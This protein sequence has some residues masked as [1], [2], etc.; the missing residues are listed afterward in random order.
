MAGLKPQHWLLPDWEPGLTIA[1]LPLPHLVSHG[2]QAAVIDVDRT[3][4]P[5]RDVQ[6]PDNVR[7]WLE[8]ASRRLR[9]HLFSNNPSQARIAAVADQLGISFTAGAGKPR[10]GALRR[11]LADLSLQPDQVAMVGDRVFTDVLCG[12]RLGLYTV[13]VRPVALDGGPCPRDRVQRI[14]RRLAVWMGAPSA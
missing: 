13:L 12:N 2:I 6:L 3:L 4:L 10:R 7:L 9:L 14:E 8:D 11:V 5:G 1:H